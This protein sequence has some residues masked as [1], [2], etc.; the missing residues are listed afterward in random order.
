MGID[1]VETDDGFIINGDK[2]NFLGNVEL[3]TYFDHR[4]AMSFFV[5]GLLCKNEI[6][7]KDFN[8]VNTSFPEFLKLFTK[9][10]A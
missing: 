2:N 9:I 10:S 8:W 6:L 3:D 7:I 1:I 4:L 5:A